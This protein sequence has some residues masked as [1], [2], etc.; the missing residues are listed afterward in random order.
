MSIMDNIDKLDEQLITLLE[1]NARQSSHAIAKKLNVSSAT[2]RRR[3]NRLIKS[4]MLRISAIRNPEKTGLPVT[5]LVGLNI[6]HNLVDSVMKEIRNQPEVNWACTTTGRF[7]AFMFARFRS[8]E[9][10]S[11]FLRNKIAETAGVK[12]S[13]T[14]MCLHFEKH[15]QLK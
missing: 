12:D 3:L 8:N 14:F 13:E 10:F 11:T 4:D 6:Q 7:D 9:D 2:V 5:V 1:Q 15:G